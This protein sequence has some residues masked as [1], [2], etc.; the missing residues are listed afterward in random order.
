MDHPVFLYTSPAGSFCAQE[1]RIYPAMQQCS[2]CF[3]KLQRFTWCHLTIPITM[4]ERR[5]WS[6][7][8]F[9]NPATW[10]S[11]YTVFKILKCVFLVN[12]C[13]YIRLFITIKPKQVNM[14]V[15]I[16]SC[17]TKVV[18]TSLKFGVC[19]YLQELMLIRSFHHNLRKRNGCLAFFA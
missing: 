14:Y 6:S 18:F 15:E 1:K 9:F 10:Q 11:R 3:S 5:F 7:H 16:L 13:N 4:A 12:F 2:Y 17:V 8:S 19:S